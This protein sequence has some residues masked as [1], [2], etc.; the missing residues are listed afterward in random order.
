MPAISSAT[1]LARRRRLATPWLL[2]GGYTTA[3]LDLLAA[4]AYW[5]PQGVAPSRIPQSIASWLLG[6]EAYIGGAFTAV[7]GAFFYGHLMWGVVLLYHAMAR[8]R[9]L[10]LRRPL[11]CGA[12]Y[13]AAAYVAIFQVLAPLCFGARPVHDAAWTATCLLVYAS[14]VGIPC[15]FFSRAAL[16]AVRAK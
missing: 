9:P 5:A 10:L 7:L 16:A 15:A 12:L 2:I 4:V 3:T 11:V 14:L 6:S 8:R 1:A 13:G